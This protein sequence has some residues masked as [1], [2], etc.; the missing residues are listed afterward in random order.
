[1]PGTLLDAFLAVPDPEVVDAVTRPQ[2][3]LERVAGLLV[4]LGRLQP[5]VELVDALGAGFLVGVAIAYSG[6]LQR[7]FLPLAAA[8]GAAVKAGRTAFLAGLMEPRDMAAPS[9]PVAGTP[10]FDLEAKR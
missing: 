3:L 1:M 9:T 2:Q 4:Q 8:F 6:F 10:F 7:G 5:Q